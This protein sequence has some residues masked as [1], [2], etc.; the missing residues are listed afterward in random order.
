M[1]SA[2]RFTGV[3]T[4]VLEYAVLGFAY[5]GHKHPSKK[6]PD[7]IPPPRHRY[8]FRTKQNAVPLLLLCGLLVTEVE[9]KCL[10]RDNPGC[11]MN[12]LQIIFPLR[13][14]MLAWY[15]LVF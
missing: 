8:L 12:L 13:N 10:V 1:Q 2:G 3:N 15:I 4:T 11:Q 7:H 6:P 14:C 9:M 5:N